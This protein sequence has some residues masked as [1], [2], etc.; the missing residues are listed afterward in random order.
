MPRSVRGFHGL[1]Q[2][3]WGEHFRVERKTDSGMVEE[4]RMVDQGILVWTKRG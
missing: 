2:L 1:H 3:K 4:G